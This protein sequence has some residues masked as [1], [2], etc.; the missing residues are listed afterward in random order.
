MQ[1]LVSVFLEENSLV[2]HEIIGQVQQILRKYIIGLFI[3]MCVVSLVVCIAF[4]AL[5]IKYAILLGIIT[6]LFN[7]IPYIG[8]FLAAAI[9]LLITFA[10][11]PG[12]IAAVIHPTPP[13]RQISYCR[14][15][16]APRSKSTP[17][18]PYLEWY[19]VK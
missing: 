9:S 16:S 8:I 2:V 4:W 6:G 12:N 14:V 19:W 7:V 5:G 17:S 1:F 18:S 15:S 13:G 3:E 10:T 11:V